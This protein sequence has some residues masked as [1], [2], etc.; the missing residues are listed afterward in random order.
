M[1]QEVQ[2][3]VDNMQSCIGISAEFLE[4][5]V[6]GDYQEFGE[7]GNAYSTDANT[8]EEFM[9]DIHDR[10]EELSKAMEEIVQSLDVIVQAVSDIANKTNTLV[11]STVHAGEMVS[12]SVENIDAMRQL[13]DKFTL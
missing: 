1:V 11:N 12:Q 9:T 10:V 4:K 2:Q 3:A 5:T 6:M 7:V 8:F 13:V